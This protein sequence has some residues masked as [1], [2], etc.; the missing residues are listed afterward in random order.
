MKEREYL[1][2]EYKKL[3]SKLGHPATSKEVFIYSKIYNRILEEFG[4]F[5]ELRKECGYPIGNKIKYKKKDIENILLILYKKYNR[6]LTIKELEREIVVNKFPA[7]STMLNKFKTKSIKKIFQEVL[8]NNYFKENNYCKENIISMYKKGIKV[9]E[10]AKIVKTNRTTIYKILKDNNIYT[11]RQEKI[12][13]RNKKAIQ[14]YK[15]GYKFKEIDKILFNGKRRTEN[16]IYKNN[17]VRQKTNR[18]NIEVREQIKE[19]I[20]KNILSFKEIAK[21]NNVS[22]GTVYY[23]R[24]K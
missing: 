21:K 24:K 22:I 9:I 15:N 11:D 19:D 7:M 14:M 18:L 5:L 12:C 20:R 6:I 23:Y 16:I 2:Q 13:Q 17:I 10:I 8:K 3:S 1:K 4:S